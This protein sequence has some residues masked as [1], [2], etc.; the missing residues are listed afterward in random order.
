M[1]YVPNTLAGRQDNGGAPLRGQICQAARQ[2]RGR[3]RWTDVYM[4]PITFQILDRAAFHSTIDVLREIHTTAVAVCL[5]G[6]RFRKD[7]TE[8]YYR[9]Q[10]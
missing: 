3:Y 9:P 5:D 1:P 2:P 6:K 7:P 10:L 8:D 4:G